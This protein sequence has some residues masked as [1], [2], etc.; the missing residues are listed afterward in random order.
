MKKKDLVFLA[1]LRENA[2]ETL[3]NISKKT[4][5]PISTLYDRL[6]VHEG[7]LITK[8]TSLI[9]FTK[10]GYSCRVHIAIKVNIEDRDPVRNYLLCQSS[11][12][13]LFKINN[14]F[15]FLIEGIFH[16]VKE[17]EDFMEYFERKFLVREK[18]VHYIIEDIR[19]EKFLS[20]LSSVDFVV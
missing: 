11:V 15:D 6:K 13:S 18:S 8:H 14:G 20:E 9:D 16:D 1:C 17:M 3:T 2:R 4:R 12:N 19:R 7:N 10:L 5:I